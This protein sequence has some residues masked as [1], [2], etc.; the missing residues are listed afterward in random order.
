MARVGAATNVDERSDP[1]EGRAQPADIEAKLIRP[2]VPI[3]Q[4][5]A[6][7][8]LNQIQEQVGRGEYRVDTQAV[9]TAIL[10]RLLGAQLSGP[11]SPSVQ[12]ECS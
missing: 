11:G 12:N 5:Q 6:A 3:G 4:G 10:R 2:S 7:V 1:V 8:R 9:A